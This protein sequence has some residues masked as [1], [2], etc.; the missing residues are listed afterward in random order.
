MATPGRI[1]V[2]LKFSEL[3]AEV[4]V[5]AKGWRRFVL[6]CGGKLV[7]VGMRPKNWAKVEQAAKDWP[8][9]VASLAGSVQ[10][11]ADGLAMPEA[12]AQ[13]FERKPK[14]SPP[15]WANHIIFQFWSASKAAIFLAATRPSDGLAF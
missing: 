1:D 2:T 15:L 14:E 8:Q 13:V 12:N 7:R 3:P 4:E 10:L 5:D 11:D 9:W 6:D